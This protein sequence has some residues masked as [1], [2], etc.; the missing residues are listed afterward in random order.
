MDKNTFC[1]LPWIHT[2]VTASNGVRACCEQQKDIDQ[3]DTD[4]PTTI[5]LP[6]YKK[7]RKEL[8]N[9][10]Q[11][12]DCSYC[13]K[14]ENKNAVSMRQQFNH[15]FKELVRETLKLGKSGYGVKEIQNKFGLDETGD[16]DES[17]EKEIKIFQKKNGLKPDGIVGKLTFEALGME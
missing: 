4:L 10:I 17:L 16:F 2:Y 15:N 11:S 8:Y 1:I 6:N 7:L 14:K 9:G 12:S 13:W 3:F 5:N